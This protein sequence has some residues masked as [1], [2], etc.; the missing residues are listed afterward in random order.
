VFSGESG[1]V[2][3]DTL[4]TLDFFSLC[5][6]KAIITSKTSAHSDRQQYPKQPSMAVSIALQAAF[7]VSS[8][9]VFLWPAI[10]AWRDQMYYESVVF[11]LMVIIS[12]LYH[13]PDTISDVHLVLDTRVWR[14]LDF[15]LAFALVTRATLMIVFPTGTETDDRRCMRNL[16][17]KMCCHVVC[18][19]LTLALVLQDI[20]PELFIM[21]LAGTGLVCTIIAYLLDRLALDIDLSDLLVAWFFIIVAVVLKFSCSGGTCYWYVHSLWH[22]L[23]AIGL[24]LLVEVL[25]HSWNLLN[26]ISCGAWCKPRA[27]RQTRA[28]SVPNA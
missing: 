9:I 23:V 17:I 2:Y 19:T 7:L 24:A 3:L 12:C 5:C 4:W 11:A 26:K 14:T 21:I 13:V 22:I 8:N 20:V 6:N 25:N 16:H 15:F 1:Y 28:V 27:A 10:V 18:D